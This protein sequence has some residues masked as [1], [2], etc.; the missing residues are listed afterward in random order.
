MNYK[1][2]RQEELFSRKTQEVLFSVRTQA[3]MRTHADM[4]MPGRREDARLPPPH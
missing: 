2:Q 3:N 4:R 1:V